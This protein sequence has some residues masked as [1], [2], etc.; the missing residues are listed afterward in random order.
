MSLEALINELSKYG[1]LSLMNLDNE[2]NASLDVFITSRGISCKIRSEF[3]CKTPMEACTVCMERLQK[4]LS[5]LANTPQ[6]TLAN[7]PQPTLGELS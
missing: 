3:D 4:F 2:W 6:P 5:D 1:K 7:T